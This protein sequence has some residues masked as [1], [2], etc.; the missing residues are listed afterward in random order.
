MQFKAQGHAFQCIR[1][2]FEEG[3]LT[4]GLAPGASNLINAQ[5][6][7]EMATLLESIRYDEAVRVVVIKGEGDGFC[8]GLDA[9]DFVQAA[10]ENPPRSRSAD[11]AAHLW[12][13]RLLRQLP[14]PVIAMVH[15]Y[16]RGAAVS[17]LAACDI[18]CV[19]DE[20]EFTLVQADSATLP[21]GPG[22]KSISEVMTQR[23]ASYYSLTGQSFDGAEAA[24]NGLATLDFPQADLQRETYALAREFLNK[25]P[26]AV[27]FT[28]ETVQ[29]VG[30]MDWDA[31]LNFTAAKF[32]ELKALQAGRPSSRAAAI[33]SFVAGK[34]KPGLG[35]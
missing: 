22:P 20:A 14:Q 7:R 28:K 16:C 5:L 10:G 29:H 3:I 6:S 27:Q 1:T 2:Q 21:C 26:L 12:M 15:G 25:D 33:E 8:A 18:V 17:V 11:E 13:G 23:A 19:A 30:H 9:A 24:R 31:A 4:I 34:S 35:A 32:A